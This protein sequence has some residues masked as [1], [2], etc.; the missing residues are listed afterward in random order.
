MSVPSFQIDP[1]IIG[2]RDAIEARAAEL[3]EED[4]QVFVLVM[5]Y[6][7]LPDGPRSIAREDKAQ[8]ESLLNPDELFVFNWLHKRTDGKLK[9][10]YGSNV[11]DTVKRARYRCETCDFA[12]V[13]ALNLEK[14]EYDE[15]TKSQNFICL[16]ANCNTVASR[17]REM[18]LLAANKRQ[19]Q[20]V[21]AAR[22]AAELAGAE[23]LA[24]L[25]EEKATQEAERKAA[26]KAQQEGEQKS[27][28]IDTT[29]SNETNESNETTEASAASATTG[30]DVDNDVATA[31]SGSEA[32]E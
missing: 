14:G 32:A 25:A 3:S 5:S 23:E 20:E 19:A 1:A 30:L 31:E 26:Q 24:R 7:F 21:A 18:D 13:R 27:E 29:E 8:A 17:A 4:R 6:L 22:A 11:L 12:D 16:C 9:R 10:M 28:T 2:N 15:A